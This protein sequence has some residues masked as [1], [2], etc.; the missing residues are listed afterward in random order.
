MWRNDGRQQEVTISFAGNRPK[1]SI[2]IY[3]Q[4]KSSDYIDDTAAQIL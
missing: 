2:E 1:K 3:Y 4:E